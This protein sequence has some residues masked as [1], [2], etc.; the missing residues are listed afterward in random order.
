[1]PYTSFVPNFVS[2]TTSIGELAHGGKNGILTHSL[3]QPISCPGTEA[4]ASE[5]IYT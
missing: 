5:Y 2:S 3:T 1:M 4:F